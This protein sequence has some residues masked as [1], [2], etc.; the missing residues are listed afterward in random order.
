MFAA[1]IFIH[2]C[3]FCPLQVI[4]PF[5][6]LMLCAE[7]RKEMEDWITALKSVQKWETYEVRVPNRFVTLRFRFVLCFVFVGP[8]W[9]VDWFLTS[10]PVP[11]SPS[12][13]RPFSF[14]L[15]FPLFSF[16][17]L[18]DRLILLIKVELFTGCKKELKNLTCCSRKVFF[19]SS[20][21]LS[22]IL[23]AEV[24][25]HLSCH[26]VLTKTAKGSRWLW[27]PCR[28]QNTSYVCFPKLQ[29]LIYILA[30]V[31][32]IQEVIVP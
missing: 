19:S 24:S 32:D 17:L 9:Q 5:R 11:L 1:Q 4:T 13:L 18:L 6:K 20:F 29:S 16:Q 23:V 21:R 10:A 7:S 28:S 31:S 22:Q 8:N 30:E 2:L 26:K 15:L 12:P 25:S 27:C 14:F 3:S